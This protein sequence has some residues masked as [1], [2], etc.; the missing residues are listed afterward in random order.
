MMCAECCAQWDVHV[1]AAL[2]VTKASNLPA[3]TP[4]PEGGIQG[5]CELYVD[6]ADRTGLFVHC[7][8]SIFS[9]SSRSWRKM[10]E[11]QEMWGMKGHSLVDRKVDYQNAMHYPRAYPG[12][13]RLDSLPPVPRLS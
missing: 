6:H 8:Q 2:P 7:D 5:I 4:P 11:F 9:S 13:F 12:A 3:G 1:C 10:K